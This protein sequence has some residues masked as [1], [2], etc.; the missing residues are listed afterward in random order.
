MCQTCHN[1]SVIVYSRDGELMFREFFE[2]N[3][4]PEQTDRSP[5]KW[6]HLHALRDLSS[7]WLVA[8]LQYIE[9]DRNRPVL[10]DAQVKVLAQALFVLKD[11]LPAGSGE[12]D[13][14]MLTSRLEGAVPGF[15]NAYEALLE[16]HLP[17]SAAAQAGLA[18]LH[19]L[20]GMSA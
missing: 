3:P 4:N 16:S 10:D 18:K 2:Q 11:Y 5:F 13:S 17:D 19:Q 6:G 7:R 20:S 8:V 1:I 14:H 9:T 15:R 12:P